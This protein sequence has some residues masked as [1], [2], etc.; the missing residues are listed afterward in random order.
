MKKCLFSQDH[1]LL[2]SMTGCSWPACPKSLERYLTIELYICLSTIMGTVM[3]GNK[4]WTQL[5]KIGRSLTRIKNW[6]GKTPIVF[7]VKRI[8]NLI[9]V[10]KFEFLNVNSDKSLD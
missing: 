7:Q 9:L 2:N 10:P 1:R 3:A 4:L 6:R 5:F 8:G